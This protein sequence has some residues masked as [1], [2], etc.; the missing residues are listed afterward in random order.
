MLK[1]LPPELDNLDNFLSPTRFRLLHRIALINNLE[2]CQGGREMSYR[3]AL[4]CWGKKE[5]RSKA[6][7]CPPSL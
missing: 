5:G 6:P 1:I 4:S 7:T 3:K 2:G